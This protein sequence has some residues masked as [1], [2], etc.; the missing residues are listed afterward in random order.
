VAL[1]RLVFG[2]V[3]VF[4]QVVGELYYFSE[5]NSEFANRFVVVVDS[6]GFV[7]F[8]H[9]SEM[10]MQEF[11]LVVDFLLAIVLTYFFFGLGCRFCSLERKPRLLGH[12]LLL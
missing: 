2:G 5:L 8:H 7:T 11:Q 12:Y 6:P 1:F 9:S 3:D 10:R 4:L